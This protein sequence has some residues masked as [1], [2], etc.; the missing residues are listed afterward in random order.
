MVSALLL[1]SALAAA[2]APA[3]SAA[4][5]PIAERFRGLLDELARDPAAPRALVPLIEME[6]QEGE[7]TDL[8]KAVVA[9]ARLAED[10]EAHPEVRA[11]ARFRLADVERSR[12]N[13]RRGDA[14][15]ARL[16]FLSGWQLAG[17]FDN[18][19]KRG[20]DEVF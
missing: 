12:G 11:Y 19:G 18:E 8:A 16:A 5:D 17:P 2:A 14:E 9:Y 7:L 13:L 10:P 4:P 20:F 6:R 3:A 1:A 15:L